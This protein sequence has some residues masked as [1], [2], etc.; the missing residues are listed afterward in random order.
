MGEVGERRREPAASSS[1][2]TR[3]T[4][5][6]VLVRH[7]ETEWSM[8]RRHTGR[9][10]IPLNPEG[11]RLA[12]HLRPT[13]AAITGIDTALVLTSPLKRARE[14][15]A[16]AGLGD[17]AEVDDDLLEWDYG[18]AEGHTTEEMR[19]DTPGWSVWT[20]HLARGETV[21]QVGARADRV[22]ARVRAH[23][24]LS[25]LFAHAHV[26]RILA[27][28]WCELPP[29]LGRVLML[30]PASVSILGHERE[31]SVIERWN[32]V[33]TGATERFIVTPEPTATMSA[34]SP[35]SSTTS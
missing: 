15:C 8:A 3:G 20:G 2:G 19:A 13:L 10:D 21:E 6:V 27:A 33:P 17:R 35:D 29:D 16:L 24:G 12:I 30:D 23:D 34:V 28:R 25:V 11:R 5:R 9:T 22:I 1:G 32:M 18:E 26:L 4:G 14:T 7:G 31:T